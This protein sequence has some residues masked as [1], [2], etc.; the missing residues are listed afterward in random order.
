MKETSFLADLG[1]H[2]EM[3]ALVSKGQ[4]QLTTKE[5]NSSR[6]VTKA[7]LSIFYMLLEVQR[8]VYYYYYFIYFF[9][10]ENTE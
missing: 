8:V 2:A 1:I 6:L 7:C 9:I 3:P 4:K 10:I 5:A